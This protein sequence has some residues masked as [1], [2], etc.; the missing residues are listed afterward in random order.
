[1]KIKDLKKNNLPNKP[2]VYFFKKGKDILYIGKATSLKS[3]LKSYFS[4]DLI[5][6][7]GPM[8]LDMV[9]LADNIVWQETESVL[10]ALI[11]EANLIKKHQPKY[12]T[13]EK[14]NKSFNYVCFTKED[15]PRILVKRGRLLEKDKYQAVYGP[16]PKGT[17]LKEALRI[18]RRIFPY[19]DDDSIKK[20]NKEFYNQLKLNPSSQLEYQKNIKHLKLFFQGKKKS[21]LNSLKKEMM[22]LAKEQK[23]E[24]AGEIKKRIFALEHINDVS[25][26]KKENLF[27]SDVFRIEAY[28]I[29]HM[30]GQ[31][32]VGVMV[33][34][35]NGEPNKKEYRKFVIKTRKNADDTGA[36]KEILERRFKHDEWNLPSLVVLDGGTAQ[37]NVGMKILK[38]YKLKMP[39]VSVVKDERHKPKSILGDQELINKYAEEILIANSE[40]HRFAIS[41]HSQKRNK[42]FLK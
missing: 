12:N 15:L 9:T 6:T 40:S 14:D 10:E 23:F 16:F 29:A 31:N 3:R 1:M 27:S 35:E 30:E 26:I 36:L 41:Y 42:Q 22:K 24:K 38:E 11:L 32:M 28:D 2:G 20:N 37:K 8:I 17:E 19:L 7:R 39:I 18:T 5:N 25:L 34:I 4:K 21:I 33:V 13:K